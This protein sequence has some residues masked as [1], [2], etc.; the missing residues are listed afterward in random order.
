VIGKQYRWQQD[1]FV[2]GP[3]SSIVPEDHILRRVDSVLDLSWLRKE[4]SELYCDTNGR[5][6]IAPEA[7]LRLMLAGFFQGIVH[8]R[9][10]IKEAQVNIAIRWF[11]GYRLDEKLP[12]H[13]SLTRIRQ[14]WGPELFK[15]I[16]QQIVQQCIEAGL[17]NGETVHID[18]TLIRADVSW[19]SLTTEY[20]DKTLAENISGKSDS[21]KGPPNKTSRT[22]KP[23]KRSKTDPDATMTTS[24]HSFRMEP[25]Y[26]QHTAVDDASGVILDVET[27]TGE[28]SEGKELAEQ[29]ERIEQTT[30]KEITK[31]TADAGYAHGANYQMLEDNDI[32]AVIPP[33]KEN[34]NPRNIPVR[35]FKYDGKHKMVRCPAGKF[36]H[37]SSQSKKGC[38]YRAKA[39]DCQNCPL[40][41]RCFSATAK[42]RTVQISDG[43]EALL[44]A[45]RRRRRWDEDDRKIYNRHRWM[46]EGVHGE[47]KQEHGLRR[48][49]RR[50]LANVSIQVYLTAAVINLKRLAAIL[51][52]FFSRVTLYTRHI[53]A[54]R[55]ENAGMDQ[56][57]RLL[58]KKIAT[59][60]IMLNAA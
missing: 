12:D 31:V 9:K 52:H 53:V 32:D 51:L 59:G 20:A 6:S 45:R 47:A 33:Q 17:V 10:L 60:H 13:S 1:L 11:A 27:T 29:I 50:G 40:C 23:K 5:P 43:Y 56:N 54:I 16:F 58:D 21:D 18:A 39:K 2:A 15:R 30:G 42:V 3:L 44:R 28:A 4:V 48:A 55:F 38:I 7:A 26:K 19:E 41:S 34:T 57:W 24:S 49:A 22:G 25:A 36:L 37:R 35:R 46:V 14:R 8:D